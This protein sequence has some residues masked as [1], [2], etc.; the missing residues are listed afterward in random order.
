[1]HLI[2]SRGDT[3]APVQMG[4]HHVIHFTH[5]T[6]PAG[7]RKG[8]NGYFAT[9][10]GSDPEV[11]RFIARLRN[12]TRDYEV[13]G[14][15]PG[16]AMSVDSV[17]H[18]ALPA[19]PDKVPPPI[20][21]VFARGWRLEDLEGAGRGDQWGPEG[22]RS[23]LTGLTVL[24]MA[25]AVPPPNWHAMAAT[26]YPWES[27][28]FQPPFPSWK[29]AGVPPKT[30]AQ[31]MA[32]LAALPGSMIILPTDPADIKPGEIA[33]PVAYEQAKKD[34]IITE[35]PPEA[36]PHASLE[37]ALDAALASDKRSDIESYGTREQILAALNI[38]AALIATKG[39]LGAHESCNYH[40]VKKAGLPR[41]GKASLDAFT[42]I[43]KTTE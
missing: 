40:L 37:A 15:V 8:Q 28:D 6:I 13:V 23:R 4:P 36:S 11:E 22:G 30:Q 41:V 25:L 2:V 9:L 1:M 3:Q 12:L 10:D 16:L 29:P 33:D 31:D 17:K 38:L 7:D 19:E 5:G 35:I 14:E 26:S 24:E 32:Q 34:G 43:L 20:R 39:G 27:L 42:A 18:V 21:Q